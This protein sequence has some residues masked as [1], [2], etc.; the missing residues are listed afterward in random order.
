MVE[1]QIFLTVNFLLLEPIPAVVVITLMLESF[2]M[3]SVH[4]HEIKYTR[5]LSAYTVYWELNACV[6]RMR[7]ASFECIHNLLTHI[8]LTPQ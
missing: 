8:D 6:K 4:Q 5:D 1:K 7:I 2:V 3:V